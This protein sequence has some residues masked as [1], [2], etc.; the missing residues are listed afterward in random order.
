LNRNFTTGVI[1]GTPP[2]QQHGQPTGSQLMNHSARGVPVRLAASNCMARVEYTQK[3]SRT[4]P[5]SVPR[6]RT[7]SP[8]VNSQT[9]VHSSMPGRPIS[10]A[11]WV[12][13]LWVWSKCKADRTHS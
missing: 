4:L 2:W 12:N 5:N 13:M 3:P 8:S 7:I 11:M 9:M 1:F 10:T 6:A